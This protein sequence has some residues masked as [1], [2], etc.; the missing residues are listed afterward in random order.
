MYEDL[1]Y[2]SAFNDKL[3]KRED[4]LKVKKPT[5]SPKE[6][7]I[8]GNDGTVLQKEKKKHTVLPIV[9]IVI[10]MLLL[11]IYVPSL[12]VSDTT[13]NDFLVSVDQ[14][15]SLYMNNYIK[16]NPKLDLDGDQLVND[17][18]MQYGTVSRR[19]DSDG[20]GVSDYAEIYVTNTDPTKY[21]DSLYKAV[22]ASDQANGYNVN[23]PYKI[24]DVVLWPDDMTSR[25]YGGVVQTLNGYRFTNYKG[26]A[27][28]PTGSYAYK[29]VNGIHIELEHKE[30]ENAFYIDSSDE[31]I[32]SDEKLDMVNKLSLFGNTIYLEDSFLGNLLSSILPSENLTVSCRKIARI[33]TYEDTGTDVTVNIVSI[34]YDANSLDR[35]GA[36]NN[37]LEDLNKVYKTI[38][39]GKCVLANLF[40]SSK[41]SSIVEIYGYDKDGNFLIADS[42]SLN[43]VGKLVITVKGGK[44]MNETGE[45]I[46]REWFDYYGAGFDSTEND[47]VNFF[48]TSSEGGSTEEETT[49]EE[50]TTT[51]PEE[52]TTVPEETSVEETAA[53]EEETPAPE[54]E[55]ESSEEAIVE[56]VSE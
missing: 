28:F 18:E 52:T 24:H 42:V 39:E 21:D 14:S 34:E 41:G 5:D 56:I 32:L 8:Y 46:Q 40:S 15:A 36:N 23:T 49:P 11:L 17:Q 6:I 4:T 35:F 16:E 55:V 45:I 12:F 54:T 19:P 13:T 9:L 25:A 1:K 47:Y 2:M 37:S 10:A 43:P 53:P 26:W 27:Q 30:A 3:K 29:V 50:E 51:I 31:I 33:D 22:Q 7:P 38:D 20:D 44:Y 48:A